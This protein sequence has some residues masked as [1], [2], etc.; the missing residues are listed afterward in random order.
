MLPVG[1][2]E[3]HGY[4]L[5]LGVDAFMP[6]A[7]GARVAERSPAL[8]APPVWYGV[9]PHHTFKPGTFTVSTET[10]QRYVFDV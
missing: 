9:S 5:P 1:S 6:E 2:T 8:L 10:F 4:H 3:Q 7:I